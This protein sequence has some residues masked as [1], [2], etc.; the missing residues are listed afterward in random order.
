MTGLQV[1]ALTGLLLA[2]S[3]ICAVWWLAPT[4]PV[5]GPAL[6]RLA[7][8]PASSTVQSESVGTQ[9]RVG[10]WFARWLPTAMWM[11]PGKELALL[12]RSDTSFY[13]EKLTLAGIGLV[14]P[15]LLSTLF[16]VFGLRFPFAVP[17][18]ASLLAAAAL[19]LLPNLDVRSR[20]KAARVE[21]NHVLTGFI[22]LVAL[23]R[24]AGSGPRQALENAARVGRDQWVFD[25]L[26]EGFTQS[27][28]DGRPPWDVLRTMGEELALPELDDLANIMALA[29]Q[30]TMPVY[31]TLREHN[32][33]LRVALLTDEQA[34][35][36]A[37]SE[38][39]TIPATMLAIVFVA[40]LLGPSLMTLM[41]NT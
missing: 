27:S 2:T 6:D 29:E 11:T 22:D 9:D 1:A 8:L 20:A 7:G 19:F 13:G 35:A 18:G 21:F 15:P 24:R 38:R 10:A 5:L 23:E 4:L 28:V 36:N 14:A 25:R 32:R 41:S 26:A 30:Q 33:A 40:I 3:V 16:G 17:L 39:L 37:T 31:Q 12:R 34:R